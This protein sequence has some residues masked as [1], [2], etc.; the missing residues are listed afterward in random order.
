MSYSYVEIE[1]LATSFS[2]ARTD[3]A[4]KL[5]TALKYSKG[6]RKCD[7]AVQKNNLHEEVEQQQDCVLGARIDR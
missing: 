5:L 2:P 4:L 7:I 1:Y 3:L 6:N